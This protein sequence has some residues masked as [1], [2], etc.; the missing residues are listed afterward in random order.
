MKRITG[1]I[2]LLTMVF[3][4]AMSV[5]ATERVICDV[6]VITDNSA[7]I[8]LKWSGDS[9]GANIRITTWRFIEDNTL[10]V[11][12]DYGNSIPSGFDSR[13]ISHETYTF[14]LRIH[15][16]KAVDHTPEFTDLNDSDPGYNAIMNLYYRGIINGYPDSTFLPENNVTRAEFSK[17][18]LLTAKYAV[19]ENVTSSFN[20][21]SDSHWSRKYIMTLAQ[22]EILKGKGEGLFDPEGQITI[23][24]VLTVLSRTFDLYN[25]GSTYGYSL[26]E[27]WSNSYFVDAVEDGIVLSSDHFYRPYTPDKK[28]TREDC[29]RL[30]S[31][32]L[33]NLHDVAE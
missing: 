5:N 28:A 9:T 4:M 21:V 12:Y 30:L 33:E 3:S 6:E 7:R 26:S 16:Q 13:L 18:L 32:I 11:Y 10:V 29:A 27:H 14:P 20:D 19:D 31:R 22:K 15:L 1:L 25:S 8:Q 23:G 2:L 24:E 17:M